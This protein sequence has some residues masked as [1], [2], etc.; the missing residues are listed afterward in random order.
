MADRSTLPYG[1]VFSGGG[2]LGSWQVG[3]LERILQAHGQRLPEV[4]AGASAGSLNALALKAGHTVQEMTELWKGIGAGDVYEPF[5]K[6]RM[7]KL[8]AGLHWHSLRMFSAKKG[9]ARAL[10]GTDWVFDTAPLQRKLR[11]IMNEERTETFF[12][13]RIKFA[14][15]VSDLNEGSPRFYYSALGPIDINPHEAPLWRAIGNEED[16]LDVVMASAS[17]PIIFKPTKG[18]VDGGVMQN[19]PVKAGLRMVPPGGI[20]YVLI[21]SVMRTVNEVRTLGE[22]AARLLDI[23]LGT[24][25]ERDI[26]D[27]EMIDLINKVQ[28]RAEVRVVVV[29]PISDL[30]AIN[31]GLLGFGV[32]VEKLIERGRKDMDRLH[33]EMDAR[34]GSIF[35]DR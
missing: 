8:Y 31:G 30:A 29:T 12:R 32:E 26:R 22:V 33:A 6:W 19:Q 4:V 34:A 16:L 5:T 28:G 2:A 24:P 27:I 11:S 21:P 14:V 15:S 18:L 23:W 1:I 9:I 7:L 17:I 35:P 25:L 20:L 13:S 3:C 10:K